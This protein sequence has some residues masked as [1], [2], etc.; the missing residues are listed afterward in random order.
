MNSLRLG[1]AAATLADPPGRPVV[2]TS[3]AGAWLTDSLI[4]PPRWRSESAF[5]DAQYLPIRSQARSYGHLAGARSPH[6]R[7]HSTYRFA[8]KL[9]HAVA[10]CMLSRVLGS[11]E[12]NTRSM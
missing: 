9:A 6:S 10:P 4:R 2:A 8:R 3:G 5:A 7:T 1:G 12:R 11:T